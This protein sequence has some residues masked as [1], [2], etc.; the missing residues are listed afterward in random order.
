MKLE[1]KRAL[2]SR[3]LN[4]GKGR[5]VFN[6]N[7]LSEIKEA[8]TKQ[9]F[10]DLKEA[11]A[12]LIKE[13]KGKRK[14]KKRKTRRRVGSIKKKVNRRKQEYVA[15]TRK[16]R[17]YLANLKKQNKISKEKYEEARKDIRTKSFRSLAHMK[18]RIKEM[19]E[20]D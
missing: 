8:I 16:L 6:I 3:A 1:N 2:A 5:I 14:I 10:K 7:R 15:L 17:A 4:V 9:D 13:K 11:G 12:I 20:E 18:D 19:G